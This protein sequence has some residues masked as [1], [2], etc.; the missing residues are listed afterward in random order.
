MGHYVPHTDAEIAEMLT[1]LGMS[2]LEELFATVPQALRLAAGLDLGRAS[3]LPVEVR[4]A[5]AWVRFS[6]E[7]RS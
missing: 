1:F 5:R 6:A 7:A 2:S 3:V 4:A